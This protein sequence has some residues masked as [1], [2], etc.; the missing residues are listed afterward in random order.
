MT[1]EIN[2]LVRDKNFLKLQRELSKFNIFHATGMKNQEI[3][4]TQ[5]LGYLL[6]PNESHGFRDEFLLRFLQSI[7]FGEKMNPVKINLMDFSLSYTQVFTEEALYKLNFNDGD[8][9]GK[10]SNRIDLLIKI[11]SLSL[12]GKFY[13]IA[14]ENKI[15]AKQGDGQLSSYRASLEKVCGE[16]FQ[17][18]APLFLY[19][20]VSEDEPRDDK[21]LP[22]LYGDTVIQAIQ[23]LMV[24]LEDTMSEYMISLLKDYIDF[25]N[26]E[27]GYEDDGRLNEIADQIDV[28]VIKFLE[29]KYRSVD[30]DVDFQRFLIR[31]KKAV[32]YLK[33]RGADPR[34]RLLDYFQSSFDKSSSGRWKFENGVV[35]TLESS[36]KKYMKF[37][38]LSESNSEKMREVCKNPVKGAV[39]SG[40]SLAFEL[41]FSEPDAGKVDCSVCLLLGPTGRDYKNRNELF[42]VIEKAFCESHGISRVFEK[43]PSPFYSVI[44]P[45]AHVG[46]R[47]KGFL[48]V[49]EAKDWIEKTMKRLAEDEKIFIE[50]VNE[51]LAEFFNSPCEKFA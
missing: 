49:E 42:G 22:I 46:Y 30:L 32:D 23:S 41:R 6:D 51:R 17:A 33:L 5:F 3:K 38:F 10:K 18:G 47:S 43:N 44:K 4:H 28:A 37:S 36:S 14:I 45:R 20:T 2:D 19:L 29:G 7:P 48:S 25:I 39:A 21:W 16:G 11:P 13:I 50:L 12:A 1:Y 31:Y 35:F 9:L 15:R 8:A 26:E 40:R 24:D 34:R 27:G